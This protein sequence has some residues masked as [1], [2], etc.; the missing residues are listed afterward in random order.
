MH[1]TKT[2]QVQKIKCKHYSRHYSNMYILII[3][4]KKT[5]VL[6]NQI[7]YILKCKLCGIKWRYYT[8]ID[9]PIQDITSV[10]VF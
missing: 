10:L 2:S 5:N 3:L 8:P 1:L 9:Q 4:D 6:R 7:K